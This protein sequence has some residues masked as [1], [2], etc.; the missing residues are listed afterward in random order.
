MVEPWKYKGGAG[1]CKVVLKNEKV[2]LHYSKMEHGEPWL[3]KSVLEI[4]NAIEVYWDKMPTILTTGI[5]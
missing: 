1:N 2:V 5:S 3:R 4:S